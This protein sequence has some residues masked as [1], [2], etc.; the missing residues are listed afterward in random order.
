MSI[1]QVEETILTISDI[2]VGAQEECKKYVGVIEMANMLLD[3]Y[4]PNRGE[5]SAKHISCYTAA[6]HSNCVKEAEELFRDIKSNHH[7]R[8]D[9]RKINHR[10]HDNHQLELGHQVN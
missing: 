8:L 3:K 9:Y 4:Y 10:L 7:R 1:N 5:L 2:I 6:L